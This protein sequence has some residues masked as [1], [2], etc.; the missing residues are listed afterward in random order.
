MCLYLP[1]CLTTFPGDDYYLR[2]KIQVEQRESFSRQKLQMGGQLKNKLQRAMSTRSWNRA[3]HEGK[4]CVREGESELVTKCTQ[5]LNSIICIIQN[6]LS[7][8][9]SSSGFNLGKQSHG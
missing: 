9:N 2:L 7:N 5:V 6:M 8:T 1:I 4:N 3:K